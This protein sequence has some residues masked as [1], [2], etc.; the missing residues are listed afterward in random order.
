MRAR[1]YP[2][3]VVVCAVMV[4]E[5]TAAPV[6]DNVIP[7]SASVGM[8]V[9]IVGGGFSEIPTQNKVKFGTPE[10]LVAYP[11]SPNVL[12]VTVPVGAVGGPT[13]E[14]AS[15]VSAAGA[16]TVVTAPPGSETDDNAIT[17]QNM[18]GNYSAD[19][20]IAST[21]L[22]H[23]Q[24]TIDPSFPTLKSIEVWLVTP[25][26]NAPT[27]V[28]PMF[29]LNDAVRVRDA[30][31]PVSLGNNVIVV[32]VNDLMSFHARMLNFTPDT[33][34]VGASLDPGLKTMDLISGE[35]YHDHS[36]L[37]NLVDT[38]SD[39]N[40]SE[41][42]QDEQLRPIGLVQDV[43]N[44]ARGKV[45]FV[46]TLLRTLLTGDALLTIEDTFNTTPTLGVENAS[47]NVYSEPDATS[48]EAIPARLRN[49]GANGN[50]ADNG[51]NNAAFDGDIGRFD[52]N[53][54]MVAVGDPNMV[55]VQGTPS[56]ELNLFWQ[57]FFMQ[58]FAAHRLRD[59][60]IAA[61]GARAA[62]ATGLVILDTGFGNGAGTPVLGDIPSPRLG[63]GVDPRMPPATFHGIDFT[64]GVRRPRV[65]G[66][67]MDKVPPNDHGTH[68]TLAAAGDGSRTV[69]G[70]GKDAQ[71]FIYRQN[72]PV[73]ADVLAIGDA[74]AR[75]DVAVLNFSAGIFNPTTAHQRAQIAT[76]L[77][78]LVAI[79]AAGKIFVKSAGNN[80][81]I[82]GT[83]NPAFPTP[84][85]PDRGNRHVRVTGAGMAGDIEFRAADMTIRK[86]TGGFNVFHIWQA[87]NVSGSTMNDGT[88]TVTNVLNNVLTVAQALRNENNSNAVVATGL[89]RF[90]IVGATDIVNTTRE[91]ERRW[92]CSNQGNLVHVSAPGGTRLIVTR[93]DGRIETSGGG[94]SYA[95]PK[96]SGL[97]A[98][99]IQ[100]DRSI[101]ATDAGPGPL[102]GLEMVETV[103]ATA[104]DLGTTNAGA[105]LCPAVTIQCR[106]AAA[107]GPTASPCN[108]DA[109]N[110]P[111]IEFGHGRINVW[112][113]MLSV[114]NRGISAQHGRT[115][116]NTPNGQRDSVFQSLPHIGDAATE[117]YGFEIITSERQAT[118]WIDGTQLADAGAT[119]P[120]TTNFTAYKGVR[121]DTRTE[122][123]VHM[124]HDGSPVGADTA[125][126]AGGR[127]GDVVEEDPMVGIVPVGTEVA[128]R[129]LYVM[130]F[131]I[132][133]KD[134][135][136]TTAG[137]GID[138]TKPK[139][140]SLRRRGVA[141][142]DEKPFFNLRL[143]TQSMRDGEVSGVTFDD[144]VFQII[145]PDYGDAP[146]QPT[147]LRN[148][149]VVFG[150]VLGYENG[151]RHHNSNLEWLGKLNP[152][153]AAEAN[154]NLKGVTPEH[155]ADFEANTGDAR[156][157]I[158][159][160]T[161]RTVFQ[162]Q[163]GTVPAF[164]DRDARDDGVIFF[165]LTYNRASANANDR[166]GKVEFTIRVHDASSMRY[167][168]DTD[169]SLYFNLWIDW[170]TNGEWQEGN[171]EHVINGLR[172]NPRGPD[173]DVPADGDGDFEIVMPQP[174]GSA[175][176][177]GAESTDENA[178]TFETR[179]R[180]GPTIGTG[181]LWARARLDYGEDAGRNDPLPVFE[182]LPSLR[183]LSPV[184]GQ[185]VG[186]GIGLVH[187]AARYGEVED[188]FIGSDFG[189]APDP[190]YPTLK[191]DNVL[192]DRGARHL[193]IHQEWLGS[194]GLNRPSATRETNAN[195]TVTDEDGE[196]NLVFDGLTDGV[197]LPL[198]I[199]S[200][201]IE[202]TITSS[203]SARGAVLTLPPGRCAQTAGRAP[204]QV[205]IPE[206][207]GDTLP[208]YSFR[209]D[210][211][212]RRKLYLSAWADWNGDGTWAPAEKIIDREINPED[213]GGD[214]KYTLGERFNDL[215]KNGVYDDRP[216]INDREPFDDCFGIDSFTYPL[217]MA[218]PPGMTGEEIEF[219]FRLAYGEDD[220]VNDLAVAE[221][222]E[223]GL[224]LLE[225]KGGALFGE[226]ED[227]VFPI[228]GPEE[229]IPTVSAW[230]LVVTALLLLVGGKIYFGRRRPFTT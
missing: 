119:V 148:P 136:G 3:V 96:V 14:V 185:F 76:L 166:P 27:D 80:G 227:Y 160:V 38:I 132:E 169:R 126:V 115:T 147:M 215:N 101:R 24:I 123:G 29:G 77:P 189:E 176:M 99:I 114:L 95:T 84:F 9:I 26:P 81:G 116:V 144:F 202:V 40:A 13:V 10:A 41:I 220:T 131:S 151:A 89:P 180:V 59:V 156:V 111:D 49:G 2:L 109:G 155:N 98:E 6:I 178:Q 46:D 121:A 195:D 177:Y 88:Y 143:N 172:I 86:G 74:A 50:P 104:D 162:T 165:P 118:V 34:V 106:G 161:N 146:I 222:D 120:I 213:F 107:A 226:V 43:T 90:V 205:G 42:L 200:D 138:V 100:V 68:V 164:H 197:A 39:K 79:E 69:L 188:Y 58:T 22:P 130:H 192:A 198:V 221:N 191:T 4:G 218:P 173:R 214:G 65:V 187:G 145:P 217:P 57:H 12:V 64:T 224:R 53:G 108:D 124:Q 82:A 31:L 167:S 208:R 21:L 28:A 193:D 137:G 94:T 142:A 199:P 87:I 67:L 30:D 91:Q 97:L 75:G 61:T 35:T 83:A 211:Q 32:T 105:P 133:R 171:N 112:K 135:Y 174:A 196:V 19:L 1:N 11:A 201:V 153:G 139:T 134:L 168:A 45:L 127:P 55:G 158:D 229:T 157:D 37:V 54:S 44:P 63:V 113:A 203:I 110:G 17:L 78:P 170:D 66:N 47:T 194:T 117:W 102:R 128:N 152:P 5:T 93:P 209:N 141:S 7:P 70:T 52:N 15:E 207:E 23:I 210:E 163:D 159:G 183:R 18:D 150:Q 56:D 190:P 62:G 175:T 230:G 48:G 16:F 212:G 225:E 228:F 206:D 216:E 182:S 181:Q 129:G 125:P 223:D 8:P 60:V 51:G 140:L 72:G 73:T 20:A 186:D 25:A 184:G 92:A 154:P 36:L 179:I 85:G 122:R 204:Q 103:E 33:L 71:V 219:R 149:T